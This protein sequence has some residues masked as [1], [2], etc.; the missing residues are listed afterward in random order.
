MPCAVRRLPF[1]SL[2]RCRPARA[3]ATQQSRE[4][5]ESAGLSAADHSGLV[6]HG[7]AA[8]NILEQE[9][10]FRCD[11]VVLGKHGTHVTEELLPG[12]V[13]KRVLADSRSDV[14]V[15]IDKRLPGARRISP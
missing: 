8:R 3:L 7:D 13:A 11:L 1:G 6:V 5:A 14:L 2:G 10:K 9:D 4:L 15:V 12:S